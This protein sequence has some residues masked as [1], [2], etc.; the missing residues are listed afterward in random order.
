MT[1]RPHVTPAAGPRLDEDA[2]V[3]DDGARLPLTR[4]CRVDEPTAVVLALHG[5]NDYANAFQ[6]VGPFLANRG[7]E[8][9]AIDQRGFGRGAGRGLWAGLGRLTQDLRLLVAL[10]RRARPGRRVLVLGES[11]GG[12]VAMVAAADPARPLNADGLVLSAPAVWGRDA[13]P[14]LYR[15]TLDVTAALLPG[16]HVTGEGLDIW[17]S[18]NIEMLR[19][20]GQDPLMIRETRADTI[21]GLV[22]LMDAAMHAAARVPPPFLVLTGLNDQIIPAEPTRTA[23]SVMVGAGD[24]PARRAA[25]YPDGWHM[26]LRD[27][28]GVVPLEDIIAWIGDPGAPL[29]SGADA[30]ARAWLAGRLDRSPRTRP[31][32]PAY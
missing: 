19:Q 11:M 21:Q 28:G 10:A 5:F 24:D 14:W 1:A 17:P 7:L 6:E 22:D 3:A 4:W 32:Y 26:L 29:P 31:A 25:L 15:A 20:L 23:L 27:L 9:W 13:M 30:R 18:D 2:V 8:V 16:L 12:A